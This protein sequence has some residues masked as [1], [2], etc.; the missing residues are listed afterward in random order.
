MEE[1][2]CVKLLSTL[3][4]QLNK[5]SL[6]RPKGTLKFNFLDRLSARVILEKCIY[7]LTRFKIQIHK[8]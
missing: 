2:R 3:K 4:N 1:N 7:K 8:H 6:E 5:K